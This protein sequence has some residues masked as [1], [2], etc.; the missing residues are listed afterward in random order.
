M[1]IHRELG[2]GVLEWVYHEA[3]VIEFQSRGIAVRHESELP[4]FYQGARL[5]ANYRADFI[6]LESVIVEIKATLALSD[7]DL[8]QMLNYLKASGLKRGLLLNFG[9]QC[10]ELRRVVFEL[11]GFQRWRAQDRL[12]LCKSP[13][14]VDRFY[15][16]ALTHA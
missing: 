14:S 10:L 5:N 15:G 16:L 13:K 4:V 9:A 8:G 6:C 11:T 3:L 1:A 12:N 2:H 7:A